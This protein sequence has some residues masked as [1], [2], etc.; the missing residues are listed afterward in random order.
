MIVSKGVL[1]YRVFFR[2][3]QTQN[4]QPLNSAKHQF[5]KPKPSIDEI[6]LLKLILGLLLLLTCINEEQNEQQM[7][8][9]D[10]LP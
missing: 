8:A 5:E 2:W 7:L 10:D 1:L 4:Y 3:L 9:K 6:K